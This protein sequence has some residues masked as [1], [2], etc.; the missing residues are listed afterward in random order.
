MKI[1]GLTGGIGSGKST[2]ARFLAEQGAV[3]VDADKVGHEVLSAN[4][5]VKQQLIATFGSDIIT[6][7]GEI[8]RKKLGDIVFTNSEARARLNQTIHPAIHGTVKAQLEE[9]RQQGVAIVVIDAALLLDAGWTP[10]MDA[11]WVTVAPE[12]TIIRR[13]R[14]RTGL[15]EAES[16]ARIQAQLS[17]AERIKH[18]DVVIDTDC[19]LDELRLKIKELWQ[20]LQSTI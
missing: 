7:S 3:I 5:E 18:A 10:L 4:S 6:N 17:S 12:A 16:Q 20:R 11:V 19:N 14:E 13:L 8:D 1:I 2:V 15:S 9:Y